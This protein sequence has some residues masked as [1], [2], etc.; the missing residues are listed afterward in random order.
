[1]TDLLTLLESWSPVLITEHINHPS[2]PGVPVVY[3]GS[4][5]LIGMGSAIVLPLPEFGDANKNNDEIVVKRSLN[6]KTRS[7]VKRTVTTVL[8]Y[9]W[10]LSYTKALELKAWYMTNNAKPVQIQNWRGEIWNVNVTT[11]EIELEQI[12]RFQGPGYNKTQV[13]LQFEGIKVAG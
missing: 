10:I 3:T 6:G 9:T 2:V 13:S 11:D 4:M 1:M 7:Y 12:G 8:D 5:T